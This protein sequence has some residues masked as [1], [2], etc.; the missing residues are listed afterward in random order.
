MH[1]VDDQAKAAPLTEKILEILPTKSRHRWGGV[2]T[3]DTW[4]HAAMGN[5]ESAIQSIREWRAI[6]GRMDLTTH[7]M[8][9]ESLFEHPDFQAINNEILAELAEL[10]ANL[11]RMEAAGELAPLPK[12][13]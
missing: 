10:R 8:V 4:L 11:A 2:Q 1:L 3:L 7:R 12:A 13:Y 6:G 5:E 9:P